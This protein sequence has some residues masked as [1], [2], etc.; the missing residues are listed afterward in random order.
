MP[1]A[2]LVLKRILATVHTMN[3][4]AGPEDQAENHKVETEQAGQRPQLLDLFEA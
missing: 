3:L 1:A 4:R 2:V